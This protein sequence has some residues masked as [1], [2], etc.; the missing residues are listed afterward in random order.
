MEIFFGGETLI[1]VDLVSYNFPSFCKTN[2]AVFSS[3]NL[4]KK[5][6]TRQSQI[7]EISFLSRLIQSSFVMPLSFFV[8]PFKARDWSF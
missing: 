4:E 3:T 6:S 8:T 2:V 1:D 5:E 7:V